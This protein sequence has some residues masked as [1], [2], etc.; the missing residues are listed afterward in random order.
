MKQMDYKM[1][2]ILLIHDIFLANAN[3]MFLYS[4]HAALDEDM[5]RGKELHAKLME[6]AEEKVILVIILE[7]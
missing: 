4:Q 2:L 1:V 7:A 3:A 6:K 5:K